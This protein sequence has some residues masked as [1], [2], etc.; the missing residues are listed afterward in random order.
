ML[1]S[2]RELAMA[3]SLID[4]LQE[5]FSPDKFSDSY[6]QALLNVIEGK[7]QGSEAFQP[8]EPEAPNVTDLMAALKASVEAAKRRSEGAGRARPKK[9]TRKTG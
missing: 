2:D 7:V 4:L 8:P 3:H 5:P 9:N 6:R 1:V